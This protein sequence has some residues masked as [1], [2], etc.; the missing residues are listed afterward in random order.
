ME[1]TKNSSTGLGEK[2]F[3]ILALAALADR[4]KRQA[5]PFSKDITEHFAQFFILF[6]V[7]FMIFTRHDQNKLTDL[8]WLCL[9]TS[10]VVYRLC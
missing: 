10:V 7:V 2:A 9:N 4:T 6:F 3:E 8:N 5:D 1:W